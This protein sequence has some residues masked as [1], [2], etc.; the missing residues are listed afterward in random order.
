MADVTAAMVKE[1]RERTQAPMGDC[2]KALVEAAGDMNKA[3]EILQKIA[4]VKTVKAA[5]KVAADG[6]VLDVLS[7]DAST[8]W[9][10][11]LNCQTDFVARGDDFKA[12][13]KKVV[14]AVVASGAAD[15]AA[16]EAYE[17]DGQSVKTLVDTATAK[18]GEKHA[19]RR[20]ERFSTRE[21][22]VSTYIHHG[23]RLGVLVELAHAK[24]AT[25]ESRAFAEEIALQV[26][27]MSP[28]W[29]RKEDV[30]ADAVSKQREILAGMMDKEDAEA[31][32]EPDAYMK[33]VEALIVERA[34]DE[35]RE[36]ANPNEEARQLVE[37][38]EKF[39]KS[40]ED[41][42]KA[43]E[44][45]RSRPEAQKGKILE[46]KVAKWLTEVVLLEQLSI[47][48]SKKTVGALVADFAKANGATQVSRFVRYEVG[49]GLDKGEKD[50]AAEVAASIAAAKQG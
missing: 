27:S 16:L 39:R 41:F 10:V 25:A 15:L 34:R 44:K 8:G 48:E 21:G 22:V 49:E 29:L 18:S 42:K 35:G 28:R 17:V 19:L 30:P 24:G 12:L 13:C 31:L 45:V 20:M 47:K 32:G 33:R 5:G 1:L 9:L 50:F 4:G 37:T 36:V 3:V 11:E 23:A 14:G 6:A 7:A 40:L 26:A 38:D 43:A 46:G 2:K